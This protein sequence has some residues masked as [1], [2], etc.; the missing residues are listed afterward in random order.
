MAVTDKVLV[1]LD[2]R[3]RPALDRFVRTGTR[4]SAAVRRARVLLRA[5]ADGPDRWSDIRIGKALGCPSMT[6][7]RVRLQF[8]ADGLDATLHRKRPT[9]R[10]SRKPDGKRETQL[11][12]IA[13]STPPAGRARWTM[14]LLAD[15]LVDRPVVESIDPATVCRTLGKTR[16]GRGSGS[17][18]SS[19]PRPARRSWPTWKTCWT[20]TPGR[21]TRGARWPAS[22]RPAG[23]WSAT[24]ARRA[25]GSTPTAR[26]TG[27]RVRPRWRGQPVHDVRTVGRRAPRPGGRPE[28][29]RRFRQAAEVDQ[30]RALP[31]SPAT[32]A[33]LRQPQHPHAGGVVRG[34]H[35]GGSPRRLAKRF[36]WHYTPKHGSW[37][38]VAEMERSVLARQCPDRRTPDVATLER[39]VRARDEPRNAAVAKANWQFTTAD[40]RITLHRIYPTI[41]PQ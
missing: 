3:Q 41:E 31:Q 27:L 12:T 33:G 29:Q 38:D 25:A 40:A 28:G 36:E 21:T 7:R 9:G 32:G 23:S 5:D 24:C 2:D 39:E 30:R 18:G 4:S 8:G 1:R 15:R 16:P 10:Q 6:A 34:R 22:T 14:A 11:V 26:Q 17:S 35:A 20:C 13:C 19:R 37:L